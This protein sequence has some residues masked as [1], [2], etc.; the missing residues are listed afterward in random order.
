MIRIS[1]VN[2]PT[3][4]S[5]HISL[6]YIHGIGNFTAKKILKKA[7]IAYNIKSC[8]LTKEQI[9]KISQIIDAQY[10]IEGNLKSKRLSDIKQLIDIKSYRGTRHIKK[11]PTRG[12]RTHTNAKT[13]KSYH[14][15]NKIKS[16]NSVK[17]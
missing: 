9:Q 5:I 16:N 8:D 4:K 1:G 17:C 7:E 6:T 2:I 15:I 3:T 12:Q 11:L 10:C 14:K 13:R